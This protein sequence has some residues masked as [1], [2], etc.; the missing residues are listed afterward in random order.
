L[1]KLIELVE[2]HKLDKRGEHI[3]FVGRWWYDYGGVRILVDLFRRGDQRR[4]GMRGAE[5]RK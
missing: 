1:W 4:G 5:G 3:Q 2:R